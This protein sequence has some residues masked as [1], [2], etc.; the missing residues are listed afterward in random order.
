M[1]KEHSKDNKPPVLKKKNK[2][3]SSVSHALS[4][5]LPLADVPLFAQDFDITEE[6]VAAYLETRKKSKAV[7]SA[8]TA[9]REERDIIYN[10]LDATI[11][12]EYPNLV[13]FRRGENIDFFQY[14][15]GVYAPLLMQDICNLVDR[16]M[17]ELGLFD[18]RA[19]QRHIKDTV[20]RIAA[21][22]AFI[23][24]R[25]F[26]DDAILQQK[27]RLNLKNGLL[28]TETFDLEPHNRA[29]FSTTQLPFS[30]DSTAECPEFNRFIQTV[31]GGDKDNAKMLQE[32]FGYCLI[33]GNPKHKVFYLHG[34]TARNGK[35]TVGKI[36]CG[37]IGRGNVSTLSLA[38]IAS[39]NT[40]IL[41][42]LV[43]KQLN[44]SDEVSS[45]YVESP[46][47]TAMSAEG[48]VEVNPKFKHPFLYQIRTK[49]L[50]ACNDIP[51]FKESQGMKHRAVIIPFPYQVPAKIRID[52][53][54]EILLQKEGA[55]IL[56][57]AIQGMQ[58]LQI[59]GQ[60]TTSKE[61][62]EEMHDSEIS[63]NPV[64]AYL[65]ERFMFDSESM[66]PFYSE[67]L[68]GDGKTKDDEATGFRLYCDKTGIGLISLFK[69]RKELK[70]FMRETNKI[71]ESKEQGGRRYYTGIR[72]V[73]VA[74]ADINMEF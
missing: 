49:F 21:R 23:H 63:S 46:A 43:G 11:I 44:F 51:R 12:E 52:R 53:Y 55:G 13:T 47:L 70:R 65:E 73:G 56:N 36:I 15:S 68:Y 35:S 59:D 19:V 27:W 9:S 24:G 28:N 6:E 16:K 32:L 4:R 5:G 67:D 72:S 37:L 3:Y 30:Y 29:Y 57:W 17:D 25:H 50:I 2:F 10:K 38:Q 22:L 69:F 45:K 7:N 41:T 14:E 8:V 61:S 60:F 64:L 1:K 26:S 18:H 20:S 74:Y 62:D 58:M 48:I 34:L 42:S 71:V 54:D 39:E 40:S 66:V 31:S 33:E